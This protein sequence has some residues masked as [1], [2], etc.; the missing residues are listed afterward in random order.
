MARVVQ[1]CRRRYPVVSLYVNDYNLRARRLYDRVGFR[2]VGE[3]ATV[4]Y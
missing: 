3:F 1:L 4:L 2:V